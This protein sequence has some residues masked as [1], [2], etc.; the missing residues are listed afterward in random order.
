MDAT[1]RRLPLVVNLLAYYAGWLA[2]V[3]GAAWGHWQTGAAVGIVLTACHVAAAVRPGIE[4]RILLAVTAIGYTVDSVQTA[5]G[6]LVFATGQPAP[7]LA[8][9]WIGVVWMLFSTTLRYGFH[10][11]AGR[12]LQCSV[13]GLIGGPA[14]FWA[15]ERLGAV[16]FN[17][18]PGLSLAVLAGL[19]AALFPLLMAIAAALGEGT[20][21][22]YRLPR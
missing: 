5:A 18:V 11:L 19:W 2:C 1:T 4:L 20:S 10:W 7:W 22:R 21:G 17:P 12:Y 13:F 16:A 3:M 14:A 15:G 9:I 8:P 6:L